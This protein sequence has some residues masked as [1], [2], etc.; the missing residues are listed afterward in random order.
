MS[1]EASRDFGLILQQYLG[2]PAGRLAHHV[3]A[4]VAVAASLFEGLVVVGV[5]QVERKNS[6]SIE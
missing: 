1:Q 6:K 5:P 4:L 2:R 3:G